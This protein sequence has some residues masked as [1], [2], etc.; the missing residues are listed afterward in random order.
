MKRE[1]GKESESGRVIKGRK[2]GGEKENRKRKEKIEKE[3]V[4]STQPLI[5]SHCRGL[6]M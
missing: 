4:K 2:K 3:S 1:E 6:R 5:E